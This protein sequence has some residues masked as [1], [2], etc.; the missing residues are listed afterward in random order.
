MKREERRRSQERKEGRKKETKTA[1]VTRPGGIKATTR[2][3][4]E[5]NV[6]RKKARKGGGGRKCS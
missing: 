5:D 6:G 4:N 3:T 2:K 1:K